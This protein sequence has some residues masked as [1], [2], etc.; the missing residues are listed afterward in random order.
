MYSLIAWIITLL[1]LLTVHGN[2]WPT[3][4]SEMHEAQAQASRPQ[5]L[6]VTS[7]HPFMRQIGPPSLGGKRVITPV[8]K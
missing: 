7:P 3:Q 6:T 1:T 4:P 5:R 2:E 8:P